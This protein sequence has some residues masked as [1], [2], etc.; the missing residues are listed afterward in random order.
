MAKRIMIDDQA[1]LER[2]AAVKELKGKLGG[3][4]VSM[5]SQA[6]LAELV[7]LLAHHAGLVDGKGKVL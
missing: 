6:E 1:E 4:N 2:R 3:K 7:L 5:L